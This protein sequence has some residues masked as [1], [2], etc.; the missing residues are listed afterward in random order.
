[1]ITEVDADAS[2]RLGSCPSLVV[3]V[4]FMS[5]VYGARVNPTFTIRSADKR[6][7]R[8]VMRLAEAEL[9]LAPSFHWWNLQLSQG[10]CWCF[11]ATAAVEGGR[12]VGVVATRSITADSRQG[13]PERGHISILVVDREH[14]VRVTSP[15]LD[16]LYAAAL[17][18]SDTLRLCTQGRG[19]GSML[20][21]RACQSLQE[22]SLGECISLYT[23]CDDPQMINFYCARHGFRVHAR[24]PNYY[25]S[26]RDALLLVR[27]SGPADGQPSDGAAGA[28]F[29]RDESQ[30]EPLMQADHRALSETCRMR[31]ITYP[32]EHYT[33]EDDLMS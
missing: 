15:P 13:L 6:D 33:I 26:A 4:M 17:T 5:S 25:R 28:A 10:D 23:K 19:C 11:I 20:L 29:G 24:V 30:P 1:M 22:R 31:I 3:I 12:T 14:Q 18:V 27:W 7:A 8:A 32:P 2:A 9:E 21:E 16:T